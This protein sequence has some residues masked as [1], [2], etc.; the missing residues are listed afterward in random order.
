MLRCVTS[1]LSDEEGQGLLEC[2]L[3]LVLILVVCAIAVADLGDKV[4]DLYESFVAAY[5]G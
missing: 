5:P 3:L 2:A 1:F 4:K